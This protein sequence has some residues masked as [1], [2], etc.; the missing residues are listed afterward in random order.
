V[1]TRC[2]LLFTGPHQQDASVFRFVN[3]SPDIMLADLAKFFAACQ[4]RN[5]GDTRF[6]HP[7]YLAARYL[8]WQAEAWAA[9]D[10]HADPLH[11]IGLGAGAEDS[12]VIAWTYRITCAGAGAWP[13][14]TYRPGGVRSSGRWLSAAK[15]MAGYQDCTPRTPPPRIWVHAIDPKLSPDHD[16]PLFINLYRSRA[17]AE[18][19]LQAVFGDGERLEWR[20]APDHEVAE[21]L[22][23][24]PVP[25]WRLYHF[26]GGVWAAK[27][28]LLTTRPLH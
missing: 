10:G 22:G 1:S 6:G 24:D 26:T 21:S 25:V 27:P 5:P 7:H 8:A 19:D 11:V 18:D 16:D 2:N 23:Q 13:E 14:V 17:V 15:V 9:E 3:G 20:R 28:D 4:A 12:V